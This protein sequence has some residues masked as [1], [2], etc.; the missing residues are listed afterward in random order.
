MT[1]VLPSFRKRAFAALSAAA[2][3]NIFNPS[4]AECSE[5]LLGGT[6]VHT[7]Y[8]LNRPPLSWTYEFSVT[9]DAEKWAIKAALSPTFYF[10][11]SSDGRFTYEVNYQAADQVPHEL[12]KLGGRG[13]CTASIDFAGPYPT[14]CL[15]VI[16]VLWL[17][18]ASSPFLDG[19]TNFL[20][21]PPWLP[22]PTRDN[23]GSHRARSYQY[24]AVRF[25]ESP[26]LPKHIDFNFSSNLFVQHI[27]QSN[28]P[29]EKRDSLLRQAS[30]TDE[31]ITFDA[32]EATSTSEVAIPVTF[33]LN[34]FARFLDFQRPEGDT[35][36]FREPYSTRGTNRLMESYSATVTNVLRSTA[37][38]FMLALPQEIGV[39]MF[40]PRF[41]DQKYPDLSLQYGFLSNAFWP[42]LD[43]A[44]V[45]ARLALARKWS[46]QQRQPSTGALSWLI[47]SLMAL[48]AAFPPLA[49]YR[50]WRNE[51]KTQQKT[52]QETQ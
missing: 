37:S 27:K 43:G 3:I 11:S 8:P 48:L 5:F 33:R 49:M 12:R 52:Q 44:D 18:F 25:V 29:S 34:R 13:G 41:R 35:N 45:Q 38:S 22:T 40:D 47:I 50:R 30:S 20:M 7:S 1:A 9:V 28:L 46:D 15:P 14:N 6:L 24:T 19:N 51:K 42:P 16:K 2:L 26:R 17:A 23:L 21:V 4:A 32:P 36:R 31:S 39:S 10:S